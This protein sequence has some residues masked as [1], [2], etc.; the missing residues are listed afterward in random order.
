MWPQLKS[1]DLKLH[2]FDGTD[3]THAPT[4]FEASGDYDP[5]ENPEPVDG[6]GPTDKDYR[7]ESL[8]LD[9]EGF[10]SEEKTVETSEQIPDE[11]AQ[12]IDD[13]VDETLE[14][15]L[16][17]GL[18]SQSQR[19]SENDLTSTVIVP[20]PEVNVGTDTQISSGQKE[21]QDTHILHNEGSTQ[22]QEVVSVSD[23]NS[24][25]DRG[26]ESPSSIE[27]DEASI[28]LNDTEFDV[29][30]P[31]FEDDPDLATL[32]DDGTLPHDGNTSSLA[33]E[34]PQDTHILPNEGSIQEQE[35]VSVSDVNSAGDR[36]IESPSSIEQDEASIDLNDT[37]FD[38]SIPEFDEGDSNLVTASDESLGGEAIESS[39][40][41][42]NERDDSGFQGV[43]T[44]SDPDLGDF[45]FNVSIPEF[46]DST[47]LTT[48]ARLES[49]SGTLDYETVVPVIERAEDSV[50]VE[51][52]DNNQLEA[53]RDASQTVTATSEVQFGEQGFEPSF[54]DSEAFRNIS[55]RNISETVVNNEG[56][57][58]KSHDPRFGAQKP[59]KFNEEQS[60]LNRVN[61]ADPFHAVVEWMFPTKK[62]SES[63][64]SP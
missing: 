62:N 38:V 2:E 1:G 27:Q 22:E 5:V 17:N 24:A 33:Q 40:Y 50:A 10:T 32:D 26:I 53:T 35:V 60:V 18:E 12:P 25:G 13:P 19:D 6:I 4:D 28:D 14:S 9:D 43:V 31:E 51:T 42:E 52:L 48:T 55:D 15:W 46:E 41:S 30:I 21:P 49:E 16:E 29:S 56:R 47:A 11:E 58:P 61:K 34:E 3:S 44:Q 45:E 8:G 23:V 59:S 37:E 39:D 20:P 36:G 64:E 57:S 54:D 7:S 63:E